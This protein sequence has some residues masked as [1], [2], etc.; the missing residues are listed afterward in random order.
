MS[1]ELSVA[2]KIFEEFL[3][4][5]ITERIIS[6]REMSTSIHVS[7]T[8]AVQVYLSTTHG[9]RSS[10]PSMEK[11]TKHRDDLENEN[12]IPTI[13]LNCIL[14]LAD[15]VSRD[16]VPRDFEYSMVT[17]YLTKGICAVHTQKENIVALKFIE[18]NLGDCKNYSMLPR[19]LACKYFNAFEGTR[20]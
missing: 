13:L 1:N 6:E 16:S 14:P 2:K 9:A 3:I 12:L 19:A 8:R 4:D 11:R 20:K 18:F 10:R 5:L 15:T 17:A 7:S